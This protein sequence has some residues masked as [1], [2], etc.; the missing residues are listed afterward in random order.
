MSL[1]S[2]ADAFIY[3]YEIGV[4]LDNTG[5]GEIIPLSAPIGNTDE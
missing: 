2:L 3:W 4:E 1:L 5:N